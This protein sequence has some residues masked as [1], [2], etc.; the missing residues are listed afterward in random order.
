M[1]QIFILL[2]TVLTLISCRN[3]KENSPEIEKMDHHEIS[4]DYKA[5]EN[6]KIGDTII[7]DFNNNNN[8]FF[9]NGS[10]NSDH[11]RIYLKFKNKTIGKLTAILL[12]DTTNVNIRFNQIIFP[13]QSSDG[14]FGKKIDIDINQNGIYTIVV[15]YSKMSNESS[16]GHFTVQFQYKENN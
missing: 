2:T 1:K 7:I 10:L 4:N 12:P 11:P 9:S 16:Y 14:P 8:S 5:L 13:N 15:G 3:I 6:N